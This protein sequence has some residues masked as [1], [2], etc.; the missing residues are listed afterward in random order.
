MV[1]AFEVLGDVVALRGNISPSLLT[2]GKPEEVDAAVRHLGGQ[3][4]PQGRQAHSRCRLRPAGR[5]P[6]RE[7][8]RHVRGGAQI[9]ELREGAA[10]ADHPQQRPAS[11]RAHVS[12]CAAGA[13]RQG[14]AFSPRGHRL[15]R[16]REPARR[17]LTATASSRL[18][19]PRRPVP[20]RRRRDARCAAAGAGERA[21]DGACRRRLH[22]RAG[23]GTAGRARCSR[24]R[25]MSLALALDKLGNELLFALSRRVAGPHPRRRRAAQHLTVA[26]ELRAGRS[27]PAAARRKPR[28]SVWPVPIRS[29]SRVT[30]GQVAAP[31]QV[32]VDGARR[33]HRSAAGALVALRR[34]PVG[35]QMQDGRPRRGAG[36]GFER[37]AMTKRTPAPTAQPLTLALSAARP[38]HRAPCR[39]RRSSM[40]APQRRAHRRRLRRTRHLRHLPRAHRRRARSTTAGDERG[41][42]ARR[43][44][45]RWVRACQLCAERRLHRRDGRAV[46]G[47]GGARRM[48]T[49]AMRSKCLPLDPAVISRD[50]SVPE[51]N[52]RR[53]CCPTSTA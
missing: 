9:R 50:V 27:G 20:A 49:P 41:A 52:A 31:A 1:K 30:H 28:C 12:P 22:A 29:A 42:K 32:D 48:S 44:K 3:R 34:L 24:E 6:G 13:F 5:N 10:H 46:A 17:P 35:A 2:T 25:R 53:Q 15:G 4:L 23:A 7:R 37:R 38:R 33:R 26:G 16:A 40:R 14:G 21:T 8:A 19:E 39:A 11:R 18:D 47:A 45:P 36:Y 51:A 43:R